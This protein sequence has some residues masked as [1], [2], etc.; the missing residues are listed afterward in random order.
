M[1]SSVDMLPPFSLMPFNLVVC[2]VNLPRQAPWWLKGRYGILPRSLH[3]FGGH[4]L[5]LWPSCGC[6]LATLCGKLLRAVEK[7]IE[8]IIIKTFLLM[9]FHLQVF[10][11]LDPRFDTRTGNHHFS[12]YAGKMGDWSKETTSIKQG[13]AWHVFGKDEW[14][15][16]SRECVMRVEVRIDVRWIFWTCMYT[17]CNSFYEPR[18]APYFYYVVHTHTIHHLV[19]S[20]CPIAYIDMARQ[21]VK[22]FEW[23]Q[24]D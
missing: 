12:R 13:G 19:A 24:I 16:L 11:A 5:V 15:T 14:N 1:E 6:A 7:C 22:S 21:K 17:S 8:D 23:W 3:S 4:E 10:G 2:A 20:I 18:E 9:F